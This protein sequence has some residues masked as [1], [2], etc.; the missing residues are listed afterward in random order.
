MLE[1]ALFS[2]R[3]SK[4]YTLALVTIVHMKFSLC[5]VGKNEA[6][7][8]ATV[9]AFFSNLMLFCHYTFSQLSMSDHVSL[10]YPS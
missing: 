5:R 8:Q 4:R 1:K 2:L 9:V 10:C 6:K 7:S 3:L